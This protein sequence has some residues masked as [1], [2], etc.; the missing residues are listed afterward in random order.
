MGLVKYRKGKRR[1][2]MVR[3]VGKSSLG[4]VTEPG[5]HTLWSVPSSE[6]DGLGSFPPEVGLSGNYP[7]NIICMVMA[8]IE[9]IICQIA[10]INK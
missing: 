2:R 10:L 6:H 7:S 1:S 3:G 5:G 4:I 8:S 9:Q